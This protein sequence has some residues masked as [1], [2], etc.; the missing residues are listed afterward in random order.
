MRRRAVDGSMARADAWRTPDGRQEA[1]AAISPGF[2]SHALPRPPTLEQNKTSKRFVW[3]RQTDPTESVGEM[4]GEV[5]AIGGLQSGVALAGLA[6]GREQFE[7]DC[8]QAAQIDDHFAQAEIG[9]G[10]KKVQAP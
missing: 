9:V 8:V 7:S 5:F 4:F 6:Q 1:A 3:L 10:G 2:R